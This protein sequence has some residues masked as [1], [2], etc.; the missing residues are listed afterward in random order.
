MIMEEEHERL[1]AAVTKRKAFQSG[2]RVIIEGKH[3]LTTPE[4]HDHLVE[5]EKTV[6]KQKISG[7]KK[8]K[9]RTSEVNQEYIDS[10]SR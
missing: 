7:I 1:R 4:V 3:I 2:K 10:Y 9:R 5:W 6:K 8:S